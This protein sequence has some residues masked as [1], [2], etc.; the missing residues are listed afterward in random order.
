M[1]RMHPSRADTK[2]GSPAFTL[3]ELLV[4]I[5]IIAILAGMLLPS[6]SKAK[7][8][9]KRTSCLSNQKQVALALMMYTSDN[10]DRTPT[11]GADESNF[12]TTTRPNFLGLIQ[13]YVGTNSKVFTCIAGR[14]EWQAAANIANASNDTIYIGNAVV[15]GRR[16]AVVPNPSG[17]IAMQESSAR[18]HKAWLRPSVVNTNARTFTNWHLTRDPNT[19]PVQYPNGWEFY[20]TVHAGGGNL[21]FMDGHAE[22][23]HSLKITSADFGL[24]PGNHTV[25]NPFTFTYTGAF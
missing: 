22:Y 10:D 5:A 18:T 1:N 14:L 23:K 19:Y 6:L 2:T 7:E 25:A 17:I 13:R 15:M 12:A 4:V 21:I 20:S 3:I 16:A 9:A 24:T 11:P 8:K